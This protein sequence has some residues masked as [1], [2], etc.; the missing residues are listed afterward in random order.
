MP[1]SPFS[2]LL[3]QRRRSQK[4]NASARWEFGALKTPSPPGYR[5]LRSN[6]EMRKLLDRK[7]AEQNGLAPSA[8][9][10]SPT[11]AT[12]CPTT[13]IPAAWGEHGGT[14]IRTTSRLSTGGATGKRVRAECDLGLAGW[15]TACFSFAESPPIS[16]G[17]ATGPLDPKS[18]APGSR[19]RRL[20]RGEG[21]LISGSRARR[22]AAMIAAAMTRSAVGLNGHSGWLPDGQAGSS[23]SVSDSRAYH[24]VRSPF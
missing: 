6:G 10:G 3:R 13:S 16:F 8:R 11:T 20:R 18:F 1:T 7:I 17:R 12:W 15:S 2:L 24:S 21:R 22:T 9:R 23:A 14:T 4:K 19:F 5:E